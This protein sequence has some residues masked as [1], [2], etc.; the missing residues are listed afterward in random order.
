MSIQTDDPAR[1]SGEGGGAL[2]IARILGRQTWIWAYVGALAMWALVT[3]VVGRGLIGTITEA[4]LVASFYFLAGSGQM[5]VIA[6]GNGNIDLSIPYTMTVSGVVAVDLMNGSNGGLV[7]GLLV[8][9]AVGIAV[10]VVNLLVI[11]VLRVEPIIGTLAVGF[12]LQTLA[13]RLT[14]AISPPSPSPV[15][16]S[17]TVAKIAGI[18]VLPLLLLAVTLLLGAVARRS[19]FGRSIQAYGQ[20]AEAAVLARLPVTRTIGGCYALSG[21]FAAVSGV[22]LAAYSGGA[23]LDAS[24]PFLLGSIAV[25][26][27]GGTSIAGGEMSFL[28]VWGGALFLTLISTAVAG[29][30]LSAAWQDIAEGVVII[31]ALT[32]RRGTSDL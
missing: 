8:G 18:P 7:P 30:G 20:S 22:L 16:A 28:G 24:A 32:L 10:G 27:L 1:P 23:A 21:L 3:V 9:L 31:I 2:G 26:V 11:R 15:L 5:F 17:F 13:L 12:I 19:L 6:L 29:V 4:A 14:Q 25:V